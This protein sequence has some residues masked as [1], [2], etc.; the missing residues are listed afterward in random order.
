VKS[1]NGVCLKPQVQRAKKG[2]G[3]SCTDSSGVVLESPAISTRE[4]P[5]YRMAETPS[6][7]N[8]STHSGAVRRTSTA[9]SQPP[10]HDS[11]AM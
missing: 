6:A 8:H 2:R 4:V 9:A 3:R 10:Q 11:Y 7:R 5:D 1:R